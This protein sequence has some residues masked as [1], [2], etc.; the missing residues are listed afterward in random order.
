MGLSKRLLRRELIPG[1]FPYVVRSTN[2]LSVQAGGLTAAAFVGTGLMAGVAVD[3]TAH[4]DNVKAMGKAAA[5]SAIPVR[6]AV[7]PIP[8]P[9][10]TV[11]TT[12]VVPAGSAGAGA[13]GDTTSGGTRS[14]GTTGTSGGAAGT[15][16]GTTSSTSGGAAAPA[17]AAP[18]GVAA[19]APA[20]AAPAAAAPAPSAAS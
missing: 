15:S 13:S 4:K 6:P 16:G 9:T 11:T 14:G 19:P 3:N 10:R 12:R 1:D 2:S 18:A 8:H 7:A 17:A 5:Y 20:A